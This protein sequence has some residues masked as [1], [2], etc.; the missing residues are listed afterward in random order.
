MA[1]I[2]DRLGP[3]SGQVGPVVFRN[4]VGQCDDPDTL[5]YFHD[6][7]DR[8]DVTDD[9]DHD[10]LDDLDPEP[11]DQDTLDDDPED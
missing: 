2:T 10:P 8:Y 9:Y 3:F 11:V 4:G 1:T 5:A 6:D 7:P